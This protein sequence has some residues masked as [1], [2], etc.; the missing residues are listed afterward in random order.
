MA[1]PTPAS[2]KAIVKVTADTAD[3]FIAKLSTQMADA[4]TVKNGFRA[5]GLFSFYVPGAMWGAGF[6]EV[7]KQLKEAGYDVHSLKQQQGY[8]PTNEMVDFAAAGPDTPGVT[9]PS[10]LAWIHVLISPAH[11]ED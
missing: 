5:G 1:I 10:T 3:T 2:L 11:Q 7:R 6:D 9:G 4:T 8:M